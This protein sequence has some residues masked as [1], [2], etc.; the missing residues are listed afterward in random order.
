MMKRYLSIIPIA[1]LEVMI[2]LCF[3]WLVPDF[4]GKWVVYGFITIMSLVHFGGMYYLTDIYGI[5]KIAGISVAG[6]FVQLIMFIA[7][8]VLTIL[9]VSAKTAFFP[10]IIITIMYFIVETV[11]IIT[12]ED[13]LHSAPVSNIE[14]DDISINKSFIKNSPPPLP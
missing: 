4:A 2:Q 14:K 6:T 5:R 1:L 7:A 13:F 8:I 11:L 12:M 3:F 10:L 9:R